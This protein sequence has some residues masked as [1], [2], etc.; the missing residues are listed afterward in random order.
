MA[1]VIPVHK[2]GDKFSASNYRPISILPHFSKIFE[3]LLQMDLVKFLTKNNII[4]ACQYG[5]QENKSTND[6]LAD[7]CNHLQNQKAI[8]KT[9]CGIFIDLKKA[10]DTVDHA[11]LKKK[12]YHY[13][14]RGVPFDL[15]SDYLSNRH[16]FVYV[17]AVKS[18]STLISTGVPQG[19]VL[20]PILFLLYINDLPKAT[21]LKTLLFADDTALFASEKILLC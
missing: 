10:F 20:G 12:L 19:S 11:I 9:T 1:K 18:D 15:F 16:Q 21:N 7:L 17:N 6:A 8:N 4:S 5:F 13:D 2:N 14:I 3:K